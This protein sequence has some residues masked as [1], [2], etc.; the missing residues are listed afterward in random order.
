[1]KMPAW[2][3]RIR[4]HE[5]GR[6]RDSRSAEVDACEPIDLQKLKT[7]SADDVDYTT[8]KSIEDQNL[9]LKE[10]DRKYLKDK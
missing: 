1:M 5:C 9:D 8:G 3:V 6:A 2:S 7:V 10:F 4:V